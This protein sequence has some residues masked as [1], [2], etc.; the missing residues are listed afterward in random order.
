M[1]AIILVEPQMGENIG[2]AARVMYNFG[3]DDLRIVN[4]RDGWKGTQVY[5]KAHEMSAHADWII[6]KVRLFES[7]DSAIADLEHVY[8]ASARPRDMTKEVITPKEIKLKGKTGFM[9]GRESNGLTNEQ[10]MLANQIVTIP[11]NPEYSSINIS[12]SVG[13]ICYEASQQ[14][15]QKPEF[16]MAT[17]G[18]ID[19]LVKHIE[20]ELDKTDFFSVP[21]KKP[22][23]MLNFSNIFTRTNLT[24][25]EVRTL[26]GVIR[27]LSQGRD[28]GGG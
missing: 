19:A 8:A 13:I 6:E 7:V 9:F 24:V 4:P 26:R 22:G 15:L 21:R 5:D 27:A 20:A 12:M 28:G 11:V 3:F 17:K 1:T 18:D 23:M 16:E 25:Q 10:I 14:S 2:A